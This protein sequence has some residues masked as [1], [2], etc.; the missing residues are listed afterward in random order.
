MVTTS[1]PDAASAWPTAD[2]RTPARGSPPASL[3]A[4]DPAWPVIAAPTAGGQTPARAAS[5]ADGVA[6]ESAWPV[7]ALLAGYP[8]W[9]ALGFGDFVFIVAAIPAIWR[10]IRWR[11]SGAR[12]IRVPRGF[13]LW[14]LFLIVTVAGIAT[15]SATAPG[16][17]SSPVPSRLLSFSVRTA[18]YVSVTALL[19]FAGNL[20]ER[21]LPRRKLAWLL[22]LVAVYTTAGGLAGVIAPGLSFSSPLLLMLPHHVQSN[23]YILA[24]M[25]PSLAQVQDVLGGSNGR[26]DAPFAYTN[27]WGN[28]LAL[29]LP[30][31]VATWWVRGTRRQRRIAAVVLALAIIP[32]IYSLNRG[33]WLGLIV[34]VCYLAV[35]LAARGKIALLA[36][37]F[38]GIAVVSLVVLVTPLQ[39]LI[40]QRLQ[41][42]HSDAHRA[43]LSVLATRDALASP[44]VG[45][46]DT[47]HEVGS[48]T[49][50]AIGRTANCRQCGQMSVGNNGQLWLL[51]I[52]S[53]FVG[54]ALYL[55]F[56]G[57]G[58][59]RFWR[60]GSPEGMAGV[61]VLLLTFVFMIAYDAVGAPLAFTMLTY[62]YLW[63]NERARREQAVRPGAQGWPGGWGTR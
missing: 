7:V 33:L 42:G 63:R 13:G 21:E 12:S 24:E 45:F 27:T 30:W 49:S 8:L 46:G 38:A 41:N 17:I 10:M 34:A 60:D 20:T 40:S 26:P 53:G 23:P 52:C 22:G 58:V 19:L 18:S 4:G 55:G 31:L 1:R 44:V 56:F 28:C 16:T 2:A 48:V 62:A 57:Y 47:R 32:A 43:Q 5:D 39:G 15:I 51:L 6:R 14:L 37:I 50:I 11:R 3:R 59:W 25:H 9:W 61:L 35:R 36:T 54:A 29:L